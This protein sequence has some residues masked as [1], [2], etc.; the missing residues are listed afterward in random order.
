MEGVNV[1]K[2]ET[3]KP[4]AKKVAKQKKNPELVKFMKDRNAKRK[5][6]GLHMAY[7]EEEIKAYS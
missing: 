1:K 2:E 5:A 3:K 7:S 4:E 6:A